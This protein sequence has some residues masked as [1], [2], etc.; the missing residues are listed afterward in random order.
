MCHGGEGEVV[1]GGG[2]GEGEVVERV[3]VERVR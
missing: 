1:E 2:S 3:V